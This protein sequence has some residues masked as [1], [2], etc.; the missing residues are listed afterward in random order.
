MWMSSPEV[1]SYLLLF[2]F[3]LC[4]DDVIYNRSCTLIYSEDMTERRV[5][6]GSSSTH[7]AQ[8]VTNHTIRDSIKRT[9]LSSNAPQQSASPT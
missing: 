3:A 4:P 7:R 1:V 8:A 2:V 6:H 5:P 9:L